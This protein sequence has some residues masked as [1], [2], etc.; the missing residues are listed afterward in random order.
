M[1]DRRHRSSN[2]SPRSMLKVQVHMILK[3]RL[4]GLLRIDDIHKRRLQA[5]PT[6]EEPVNIRLL[7]KFFAV[8]LAHTPS[9]DDARRVALGTQ[10]LADGGVNLLGLLVAGDFTGADGPV[11]ESGQYELDT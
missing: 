10:P 11:E 8:L 1:F 3:R 5:R 6:D 7:S 2:N 4:L 9:V